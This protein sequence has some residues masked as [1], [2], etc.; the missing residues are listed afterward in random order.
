MN[1][2]LA[3]TPM[4][5]IVVML[6]LRQSST[7]AA[8]IGLIAA[9]AVAVW[10]FG[11]DASTSL[12][13]LGAWWP[14]VVEVLLI[15]AGGV[16]FAEA[17][18]RTGA[19][20]IT[21]SWLRGSLGTGVAPVLAI[22]HGA[23]PFAESLT[24]FGIGAIIAVPLLIALGFTSRKA[25][26]IGLLGLCAVPWGSLGPGT[27]VA[28]EL[29]GVDYQ[30]LGVVSALYSLPVFIGVG[31]A[32]ALLTAEP[33]KRVAGVIAACGS[34]SLLCAGVLGA[35][36]LIGTPAA[37]AIGALLT[38]LV[39]LA[40]SR[41]RGVRIQTPLGLGRALVPYEVLLGGV[42]AM[43]ILVRLLG[44]QET[45]LRYLA[46]PTV[47]LFIATAVALI[48]HRSHTRPTAAYTLHTWTHVGPA[49]A[50]FL[51]FGIVMAVSGMSTA[52][53]NALASLG[54]GYL[55]ALPFVG[56]LGGFLTGSNTGANAMFASTQ[57]S[58][59]HLIGAD[60]L[61]AMGAHN[62]SAALLI[63]AAPARVELAARLSPEPPPR[64][65]IMRF[66]LLVD[67]GV[68][69]VIALALVSLQYLATG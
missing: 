33:G 43:S 60:P 30:Q 51:I 34:G 22:V 11:L 14:L 59:A 9:V 65:P 69:A 10:R 54:D 6:L 66:L 18:R 28:A 26:T 46:S 39:H 25:V 3:A 40:L 5:L 53:A 58:A 35:N 19:Q 44:A 37:G 29:G 13:A 8:A 17:G 68:V 50:M 15:I 61:L 4:L 55:F 27:L 62:V 16:A 21:A 2:L 41:A 36:L 45:L 52:V 24:G 67:L 1:L 23:T 56:A 7:R 42:V 57:A 63:M 48:G 64:G 47:W 49:T 12:D 32:A 31:I 38:L 20:G